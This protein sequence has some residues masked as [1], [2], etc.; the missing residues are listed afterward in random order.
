MLF[1]NPPF[2]IGILMKIF[3]NSLSY[4]SSETLNFAQLN[5]R[6]KPS[7]RSRIKIMQRIRN[8]FGRSNSTSSN[9]QNLSNNTVN[10]NANRSMQSRENLNE[11]CVVDSLRPIHGV[12]CVNLLLAD[13]VHCDGDRSEHQPLLPEQPEQMDLQEMPD[14]VFWMPI[15]WI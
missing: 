10:N 11:I 4:F 9:V 2:L 5:P 6:W 8:L 13:E 3:L 14:E 7:S 12:K 1:L 15:I